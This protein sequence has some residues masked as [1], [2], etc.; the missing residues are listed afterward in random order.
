M[1]REGSLTTLKATAT[2]GTGPYTY[3]WDLDNN[4]SFETAGRNIALTPRDSGIRMVGLRIRDSAGNSAFSSA[5]V[6]VSNVA[7]TATA[8]GPYAATAGQSLALVGSATDPSSADTAAGFTY[9]WTFG[10]GTP[11]ASGK[12]LTSLRH[13]YASA[14]TYTTT[15]TVTDKDGAVS[16]ATT[17]VVVVTVNAPFDMALVKWQ[18]QMI[19]YGRQAAAAIHNSTGETALNATYYDSAR[20]FYQIADYTGDSSWLGA[21]NDSIKIYRDSYIL[22][23]DGSV[24]G[25][26]NFT[27]GL[28]VDYLHTG[29][30]ASRDAVL[31]MAT[32]MYGDDSL[33]SS[34]TASWEMSREVAYSL[35][36][37]L[38]AESL[39]AP[40]LARTDL[41]A[42]QALGH[43]DQWTVSQTATYVKPF[44]VALTCEA[45][46]EY[47]AR[48]GDS[49]VLP[50]IRTALDWIWAHCW[51]PSARAFRYATGP[52]PDGGSTEPAPD[53]N[54]LIAP[55]Y[56][57]VYHQTG[58]TTS[59]DRGD[60]TFA[61]GVDQAWL[62]GAKQFD[63]SYRWSFDYVKWRTEVPLG[64]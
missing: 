21:A 61:G 44:M 7:P 10:D 15:L 43:L 35:M 62:A 25:Y 64:R 63:Q 57:W 30:A 4:G 31:A 1:G 18:S 47:Q 24:P 51:D 48:T 36:A 17:S 40:H 27:D 50:A 5:T 60:A 14:G 59:R 22:P 23:N 11:D 53:L 45:L 12:G 33:A 29:N 41:L 39:G 13:A 46:I 3:A 9:T 20:V 37:N 52:T 2:G 26:W 55:A 38:D 8:G 16:S 54:L 19:R 56:A 28:K 49:R 32:S 42:D 6:N 58:D 34:D